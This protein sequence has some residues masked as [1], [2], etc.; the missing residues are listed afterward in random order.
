MR[1]KYGELSLI[2]PIIGN[3][4]DFPPNIGI[5][6]NMMTKG[7]YIC[8]ITNKIARREKKLLAG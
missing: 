2:I 3:W 4:G 5:N 1:G 8:K 7:L 6:I